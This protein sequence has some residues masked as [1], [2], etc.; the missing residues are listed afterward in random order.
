MATLSPTAIS[1]T[2]IALSTAA[3]ADVAGDKWLNDGSQFLYVKNG[4]SGSHT[5]T[6]VFGPG[7][8]VDGVTPTSHAVAVA[9]GAT[10]L[11]GPF[12]TT[13]YNDVNGF[14][15]VTYDAVTVVTVLALTLTA[16]A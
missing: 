1:R 6:L 5:V 14:M 3:A 13:I 4:D 12:P 8:V 16:G 9:A 15:N 7:A 2:G 11:I 10:K